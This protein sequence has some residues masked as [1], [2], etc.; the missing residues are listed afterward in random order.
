MGTTTFPQHRRNY[1]ICH[2]P[3]QPSPP[4]PEATSCSSWQPIQTTMVS[5]GKKAS[6]IE[7]TRYISTDVVTHWNLPQ[8]PHKA[9][10]QRLTVPISLS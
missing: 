10:C 2:L 7:C 9:I 8:H 1:E 6:V 3:R 5:C 4:L